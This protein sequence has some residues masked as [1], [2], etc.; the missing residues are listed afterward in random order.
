[1]GIECWHSIIAVDVAGC[2]FTEGPVKFFMWDLSFLVSV[3]LLV[4]FVVV[5]TMFSGAVNPMKISMQGLCRGYA[6]VVDSRLRILLWNVP[7]L[8]SL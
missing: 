7:F 6:S 5:W 2:L 4:G 1:M 3:T 8:L